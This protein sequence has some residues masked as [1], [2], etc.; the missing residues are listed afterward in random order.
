MLEIQ[1][2]FNHPEVE[3][4]ELAGQRSEPFCLK[5]TYKIPKRFEIKEGLI[6]ILVS[7][8]SNTYIRGMANN[9]FDI[10]DHYGSLL[11]TGKEYH[12]ITPKF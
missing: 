9:Y 4:G 11:K 6:Y 7:W 10:F 3:N 2:S 1:S 5:K 12:L 8:D